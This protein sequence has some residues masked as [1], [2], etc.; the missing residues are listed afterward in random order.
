MAFWPAF[1][2]GVGDAPA[3]RRRAAPAFYYMAT[4]SVVPG[5]LAARR[6][7]QPALAPLDAGEI[8]SLRHVGEG[9]VLLEPCL[10]DPIRRHDQPTSR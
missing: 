6:V 1:G 3:Q 5:G 4:E 10:S 2:G 7:P 8:T 9:K